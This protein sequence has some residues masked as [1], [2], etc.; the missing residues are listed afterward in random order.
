[1]GNFRLLSHFWKGKLESRK[2]FWIRLQGRTLSQKPR[3]S[4]P[5][6]TPDMDFPFGRAYNMPSA[7]KHITPFHLAAFY[8]EVEL[9]TIFIKHL[10]DPNPAETETG[11]TPLHYAVA[12]CPEDETDNGDHLKICQLIVDSLCKLDTNNDLRLPLTSCGFTT[13]PLHMAATSGNLDMCKL[14]CERSKVK[15]FIDGRGK[16][17]SYLANWRKLWTLHPGGHSTPLK[18]AETIRYLKSLTE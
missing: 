13:T 18:L 10:D 14:F 2:S 9:C 6:L 16:T 17:P 4:Y 8:G 1:M 11:W 15:T 7:T 5:G 12:G 3:L